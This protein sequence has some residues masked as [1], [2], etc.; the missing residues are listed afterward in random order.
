MTFLGFGTKFYGKTR[1]NPENNSYI[2][3]KWFSLNLIPLFPIKSYRVIKEPK[4]KEKSFHFTITASN[5]FGFGIKDN[6]KQFK[7]LEEIPLNNNIKQFLITYLFYYGGIG[8]CILS[9]FL[10]PETS[11]FIICIVA[12]AFLF[13]SKI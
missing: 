5:D 4:P 9:Y 7:I 8:L 3:T 6:L 11:F 2:T 1:Y 13:N 12:T 10:F